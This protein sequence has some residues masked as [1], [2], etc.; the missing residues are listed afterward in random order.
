MIVKPD[1]GTYFKELHSEIPTG[2]VIC[3]VIEPVT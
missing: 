2:A 1:I 3:D